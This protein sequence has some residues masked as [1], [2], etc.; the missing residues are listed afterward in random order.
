MPEMEVH[1]QAAIDNREVLQY[2]VLRVADFPQWVVIAAFYTALHVV[3]S[4]LAKDGKHPD[5]HEIR[6]RLLRSEKKYQNLWRHYRPLWND[7]LLAR[8]LT[9]DANGVYTKFSDYMTPQNV[10]NQH[11]NH[12][13][14]QL[15]AS[16]RHALKDPT[17][18][19]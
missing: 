4:I 10:V 16:A 15:I 8:Y 6:N 13:L 9:S 3:E 7:S 1:R 19:A 14:A 12:H 2:L 5:S 11:V 18:M 17:F